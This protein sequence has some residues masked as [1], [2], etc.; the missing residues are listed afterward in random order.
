[1][2][3]RAFLGSG[4]AGMAIANVTTG[5]QAM[6]PEVVIEHEATG[7]PRKGKV[8][9]AIQPHADDIPLFAAGTVAKLID[10]GATGYLIRVTNDDKT[11]LGTVGDGVKN[12][13]ADNQAVARAL[14]C[15][16][17]YDLNYRNHNLD[18]ASLVDLR[19]RFIFL[20]RLLQV[21]TVVC[22]DPWSLYE[23]NPDHYV[24]ARAVEA[25]CWMA[26]MGK[27]YPEH[28]DAGMKA[29][30]VTEKYYYA[31]GPQLVNRVVDI[32]STIDRKIDSLYVNQTQGPAGRRGADLRASLAARGLQLP[33][34]GN[35]DQTANREYIRQFVL[36]PDADAGREFNLKF[37]ERFHY[38]GPPAASEVPE[39]VRQYAVPLR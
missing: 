15:R 14:G 25:A 32:S 8:V 3:R 1:M 22:Y 31:R 28:F 39:Y 9:A 21:D 5:P 29:H 33:I 34:L 12:N 17:V 7:Q 11:G 36:S 2:E 16:K 13:E 18:E 20:F 23:E 37:A 27:D 10:E 4:F 38:I 19:G 30:S 6:N 26:G 35:D 24:T